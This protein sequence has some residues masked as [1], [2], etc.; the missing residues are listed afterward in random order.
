M[1]VDEANDLATALKKAV[2]LNK[3]VL[4]EVTVGVMPNPF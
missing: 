2:D 1:R 3:P 4:I